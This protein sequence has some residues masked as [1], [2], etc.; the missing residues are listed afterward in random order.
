MIGTFSGLLSV[1]AIFLHSGVFKSH[2]A[3]VLV[4]SYGATAILLFNANQVPLAQPRN[5]LFGQFISALIGVIILKLFS[6]SES[7]K[8]HLYIGA[9]LS[10]A[11]ASVMMNIFN[12]VHP[13]SGATALI[14]L[15]D[16]RIANMGWWYLPIQLVS[17]VVIIGIGLITNNILR[18]YPVY[19]WTSYTK[20]KPGDDDSLKQDKYTENSI[21]AI[22]SSDSYVKAHQS[23]IIN[24]NEV[25]LPDGLELSTTEMEFLYEIKLKMNEDQEI[26]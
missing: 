25:I 26:Q 13:P 6:L 20:P 12:C 21:N 17:S 9:A 16:D 10:T 15:I 8:D 19:W 2:N 14:P 3:P 7:G 18:R 23:L 5:I 24:K 1:E 4:A 22:G 11:I